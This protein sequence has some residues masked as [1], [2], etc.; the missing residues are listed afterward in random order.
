MSYFR[1]ASFALW[2]AA[3]T[4]TSA[5]AADAPQVSQRWALLIG[6]DDYAY[7][8]KL[9]YCGADQRAMR[10]QL[11]ASGFPVE[12]IFLLNDQ[13]QDAQ[14]RPT[15]ANIER[16][17][18][19]V[20]NL[21]DAEDFVV[22]AFSGHGVHLDA[23]S[24][25]CPGDCS[26]EDASSL[27]SLDYVYDELHRCAAQFK[28]VVVDACRNDPR[29]T[30]ARSLAASD[31]TRALART[32]QE[33]KLPE[34]VVLL[35]SCAP[36]EVSWEDEA[37][38]HGVFMHFLL[39]GLQGAADKV[40]D[41][42]VS[43]NEM[44]TYA[45]AGT[46]GYVANRFGA[47]QRPFFKGDLSTEALEF[48]LLPV[49]QTGVAQFNRFDKSKPPRFEF[50]YL[51]DDEPALVWYVWP[52]SPAAAAGMCD[53]D[54][55]V[56]VGGKP[57]MN[58]GELTKALE[59]YRPGD[60]VRFVVE[61]STGRHALKIRPESLPD[62]YQAAALKAEADRGSPTAM[63]LIG[64]LRGSSIN[65]A[66][67]YDANE[68]E[69]WIRRAVDAGQPLALRHLAGIHSRGEGVDHDSAETVRLLERALVAAVEAS[70]ACV[71]PIAY[72]LGNMYEAGE[73]IDKDF[74]RARE[75]YQQSADANDAR[76]LLAL[77]Y[78]YHSGIGV[79]PNPARVTD[80]FQSA[81]A[82]NCAWAEVELG[83]LYRIGLGVD[84]DQSIARGWFERSVAHGND[85]GRFELGK[86]LR[87]GRGGPHDV[88][89][90][91]ELF[92][93]AADAEVPE[94]VYELGQCYR[95][96]QG[97][98]ID[99]PKARE[100]Y[101]KAV[102]LGCGDAEYA[103]GEMRASG[104]T[105]PQNVAYAVD[106]YVKAA[107][108]GSAAACL[109]LG[110][111]HL[112]GHFVSKSLEDSLEYL[113]RAANDESADPGIRAE[114]EITIAMLVLEGKAGSGD[115]EARTWFEYAAEHESAQAMFQLGEMCAAGQ[116]GPKDLK[117]A[118]VWYR[119]A[120]DLGHALAERRLQ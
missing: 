15:H 20:L 44:Q 13:A 16:H 100:L 87:V 40:G 9:S 31:G 88:A 26:L 42:H 80:Y 55:V 113:Q 104:Q 66:L 97:V 54:V 49:A 47:E 12:N 84:Q 32:L 34:G 30:G 73:G 53:Y 76:G 101:E 24:F 21:A 10:E 43:L 51:T 75:L 4:A 72:E 83:I 118:Q 74:S 19:L 37:F 106:H 64:L 39:D 86:M 59:D 60:E 50:E 23:K 27:I 65:S 82:R 56:E 111:F 115:S 58:S 94:A 98:A 46:K 14:L 102:E 85:Y 18:K 70:P 95:F 77:G 109:R 79:D 105:F 90:A 96:G 25:L 5:P 99:Y 41:G 6:V 112:T 68:S 11:I 71:G 35:N 28:L 36:G 92:R 17:L 2:W 33:V 29:P 120:A 67:T 93:T 61:R 45:S 103:I 8:Q 78:L 110:S 119:K 107:E 62:H 52:G 3:A 91:V 116:G 63:Y 81:A 117:Q 108:M 38:G 22:I 1:L 57:V 89:R 7:A 69:V 48:A 114:A